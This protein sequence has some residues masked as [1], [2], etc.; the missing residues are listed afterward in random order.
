MATSPTSQTPD[1]TVAVAIVERFIE[2]GV[3]P[4]QLCDETIEKLAAGV[5]RAGDWRKLAEK[6]IAIDEMED[7]V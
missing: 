3:L 5:L 7:A 2:A 6:A 4:I 1:Q